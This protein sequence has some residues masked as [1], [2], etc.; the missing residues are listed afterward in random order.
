MYLITAFR[1]WG[2]KDIYEFKAGLVYTTQRTKDSQDYIER[3]Y[4]QKAL[5][6]NHTKPNQTKRCWGDA[7]VVG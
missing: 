2:K 5:K 3:P 4:F 1:R 6:P 7:S